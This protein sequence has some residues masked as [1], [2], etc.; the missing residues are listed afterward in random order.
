[1]KKIFL[2]ITVVIS[3]ACR[4]QDNLIS[5][6][7]NVSST[8]SDYGLTTTVVTYPSSGVGYLATSGGIYQ[9]YGPTNNGSGVGTLDVMGIW[10]ATSGQ[11]DFD[12]P[13]GSAGVQ[14]ITGT[15]AP[16]FGILNFQ[17]GGAMQLNILNTAGIDVAVIANY[18][19]GITTTVRSNT[20]TGAM[21]F[22]NGATYSGS[23]N[24][25]LTGSGADAQEVNGYVGKIGNTSFIYPVGS[26]T[27]ARPL[28]IS[29]PASATDEYDVAWIAGNPTTNADPSDPL[30]TQLHPVSLVSSPIFNVSGAGQWDWIPV[31]GTGAGLTITVSIPDESA[32]AAT[33]NLRLVGWNG[34][35]WI[36]L[37]GTATASG[38]TENSTLSGTMQSGITAIGIGSITSILTIT[39]LDFNAVKQNNASLLTWTTASEI[40][41]ASFIIE[42]S[43]DGINFTAI[44][45]VAAVGNNNAAQNYNFT[46]NSP[47]TGTNYYRL[48]MVDKNGAITYSPIRMLNFNSAATILVYPNPAH[49]NI[50]ITGV[51]AGM[52]LRIIAVDGRLLITK[53]ATGNSENMNVQK[54]ENGIYII[55]AIKDGAVVNTV[56]FNKN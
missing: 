14:Q 26:G 16:I 21:R 47:A 30:A 19:N 51:E 33:S 13:G 29:A 42:H 6:F 7:Y 34:S 22:F 48:R 24:N 53:S 36:D 56:K 46:D 55:Q 27:D 38:N 8:I 20:S 9:H 40:S 17:N 4:A 18:L 39:L 37:S 2:A 32:F 43:R 12:G 28:Q 11:D 25:V 54:L 31:S 10:N 41:T 15:S 1:M 3:F 50:T 52:Q 35:K 44:G 45:T 49:D 5:D 23:V